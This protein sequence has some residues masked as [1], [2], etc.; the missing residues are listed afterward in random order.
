ME[1]ASPR[2]SPSQTDVP[3]RRRLTA[4][5]WYR[6]ASQRPPALR[7]T[8]TAI[9][10]AS[11]PVVEDRVQ[12]IAHLA[13]AYLQVFGDSPV[14]VSR[15]PGRVNLM[16][17]HV[18]HQGGH[19]NMLAIEPDVTVVAG[20]AS[21][22]T[23]VLHNLKAERFPVARVDFDELLAGFTGG[24]WASYVDSEDARTRARKANGAWHYYVQAAVARLLA[25]YPE[26]G[27]R[28]LQAVVDGDIPIAAGLSSSSAL[29]V[30]A[31]EALVALHGLAVPAA[32]FVELC[33]EAEWYVGT[34]GGAGDHAAMTFAQRDKVVQL[35]FHPLTLEQ[36]APW[37]ADYA[38]LVADS[39]HEARKS[40]AARNT[41][42]QR[43]A[44]YHLA[45]E[46]LLRRRP[47]LRFHVQHLRDL[48]PSAL[49]LP[50][51]EVVALLMDLPESVFRDDVSA[52]VDGAVAERLLA[53]HDCGDLPYRI[54]GVAL[55]GLAECERSRRCANL[56]VQGDMITLGR[57]MQI[58]HDGDRVSSLDG[59]WK[60]PYGIRY[61]D[62]DVADL[63]MRCRAGHQLVHE[64]GAYACSTPDI[65]A[66]VDL[67]LRVPGV[68]GAQLSGAGLGGS[69]M[70]LMR[71]EATDAARSV[72]EREYY[73]PRGLEPRVIVCRPVAGC[74]VLLP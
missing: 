73:G 70:A 62:E 58:S 56:L 72:L 14:V 37:P 54:R 2:I 11:S 74:G 52:L 15:A 8:L 10:G 28:G 61:A 20:F 35:A 57:W 21:D 49:G 4:S 25:K 66:M 44:C 68:V 13:A 7:R 55:F 30:A 9:Y 47:R 38:L 59:S 41:F 40:G 51:H 69:M 48:T 26:V 17:R 53:T 60:W 19:C 71:R 33:A 43:V 23:L 24:D 22:R 6:L 12:R 64:P 31:M 67:L 3:D 29:V 36:S 1:A 32:Q 34:R 65:D 46:I 39:C 45:R 5:T 50:D 42:N 63:A 16:G 27:T 18:D